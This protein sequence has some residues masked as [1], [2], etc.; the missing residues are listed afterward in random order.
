VVKD[1]SPVWRA[2]ANDTTRLTTQAALTIGGKTIQP[3]T[4][5]VFVDLKPGA[6]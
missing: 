1:G 6:W 3:G 2:G 4:Y 5:N